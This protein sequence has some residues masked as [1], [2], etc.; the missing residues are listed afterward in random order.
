MQYVP[1]EVSSKL[2]SHAMAY[3]AVKAALI[4]ASESATIFPVVLGHGSDP[5]NTYAVKSSTV[6]DLAGLK[7]GSYWPGNDALGVP[8]H[9]SIILLFDQSCGRIGAAVE[10]GKLNAFRTAAADAVAADALARSD[11]SILAVFG[12]GHQAEYEVRALAYIRD[13]KRVLVVTRNR[14][15][16]EAF[17]AALCREGIPSELAEPEAACREADI[18]V[19]VTPAKSPLFEA[20]WVQPGTHVASMGSDATGKQELPPELF[21]RA[22]LF[23]DLPAQSRGI[24][25]FQHALVEVELIAI[26]DVLTGQAK[27]RASNTDITIFDS[28]GLSVQD[29][30]VAQAVLELVCK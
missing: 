28:S 14:D 4:A 24:G 8:R 3:D 1:E 21:E 19:T 26:G 11:A 16:G 2:A 13:L 5:A 18:I 10:A 7:V 23:C 29:L 25:E 9:N 12:A 15:K 6:A 22:R 30:F 20:A 27:G 17:V